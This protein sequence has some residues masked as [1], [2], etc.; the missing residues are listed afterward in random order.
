V[1][2]E[3]AGL[4]VDDGS[5]AIFVLGIVAAAAVA[6]LMSGL[7]GG[8]VLL[9]GSLYALCGSVIGTA[10][11]HRFQESSGFMDLILKIDPLEHRT[12]PRGH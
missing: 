7:W 9:A 2:R 4:F 6:R 3:L 10:R 5:L 12:E 11:H 1:L 8:C